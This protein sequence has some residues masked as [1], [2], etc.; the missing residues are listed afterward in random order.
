MEP[1]DFDFNYFFNPIT[2]SLRLATKNII[3]HSNEYKRLGHRRCN[4]VVSFKG[5]NPI[6]YGL[7]KY[8][9]AINGA[10][11]VALNELEI[12]ENIADKIKDCA[13]KAL[14]NLKRNGVL[15]RFFFSC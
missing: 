15:N 3:Y 6:H 11:F 2:V 8:F 7:I 13:C 4:Y 14:S 12:E 1:F 9:L 10:L 5:E